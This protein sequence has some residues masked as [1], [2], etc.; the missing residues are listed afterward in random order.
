MGLLLGASSCGEITSTLEA[1]DQAYQAAEATDPTWQSPPTTTPTPLDREAVTRECGFTDET[2]AWI[3]KAAGAPAQPYTDLD[4]RL[5]GVQV[6]LNESDATA[7]LD[8]LASDH[9]AGYLAFRCEANSGYGPD[10]VAFIKADDQYDII[11]LNQTSGVVYSRDGVSTTDVTT[12]MVIAQLKEWDARF[13][14]TITGAGY[15]WV[16]ARM[17]TPP[18]RLYAFAHEVYGFSPDVVDYWMGSVQAL[19]NDLH[20]TKTIYLWWD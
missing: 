6:A 15:N 7:L 18:D 4:G 20:D 12:D 8:R 14:L 13:D 5:R 11:R 17:G 9:R 19:A 10:K 1:Y 3:E 16:E 2:L